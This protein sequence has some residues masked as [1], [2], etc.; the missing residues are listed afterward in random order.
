MGELSPQESAELATLEE[1]MKDTRAWFQPTNQPS[2][3][4]ALALYEKQETGAAAPAPAPQDQ[5][6]AEIE[7][8]M[9]EAPRTYW[10]SADLQS[11]YRALLAVD[12]AD[13][14]PGVVVD[15]EV[16]EAWAKVLGASAEDVQGLNQRVADL[17]GGLT[18][19][20]LQTFDGLGDET[21]AWCLKALTPGNDPQE[22][23]DAMPEEAWQEFKAWESGLTADEIA[24][25][26]SLI[27]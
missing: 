18:P 5:R 27:E 7:K 26:R 4:R 16:T 9:A 10:K 15:G 6:L 11:E 12:A 1:G 8:T 2:R 17:E 20:S 14:V 3:D 24:A 21:Q 19:D 25:I 23:L 13:L 22:V